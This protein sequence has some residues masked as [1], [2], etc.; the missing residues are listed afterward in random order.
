MSLS[1]MNGK[2]DLPY[3]FQLTQ[4]LV[5]S[6]SMVFGSGIWFAPNKAPNGEKW[7]GPYFSKDDNG[8]ITQTMEYST[9]SYNYPQFGWYKAAIQGPKTVFWDEPAYDSV[10]DTTMMSSSAPIR[11]SGDVVGVVTVDIG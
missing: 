1:S 9:E 6:D 8:K 5:A 4:D 10:S 2:Y 3:A 11:S 7:F